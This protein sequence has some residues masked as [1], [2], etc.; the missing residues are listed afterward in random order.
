M[1][2][3]AND[4]KSF[5]KAGYPVLYLVSWEEERVENK[6]RVI[7]KE[8]YGDSFKFY[9]WSCTDGLVTYG[10]GGVE[11]TR[12]VYRA[13]DR[14]ISINEEAFF[15]F[16]DLSFFIKEPQTL[17]RL[18]DIQRTL[19]GGSKTL[20]VLSSSLNLPGELENLVPVVDIDLPDADEIGDVFDSVVNQCV[21]EGV[22][23]FITPEFRERCIRALLGLGTAEIELA[24]KRVLIGIEELDEDR[25][26]ELLLEEKA[27]F[28]RKSGTLEFVRGRISLD[29]IG[30]LDNLKEWL[31]IRSLAFSPD[32][33]NFGLDVPKGVLIMGISGCGKSLCAKAI[34]TVWGLPLLRLDLNQVY[35]GSFGTPEEAFR[36]AIKTVEAVAPCVLWI[37]EIEAGI[38]RSG[39]KTGDSPT[40]RIFGYFLTWMQEKEKMVFIAAT[41]NQ[42]DL[43]PPELLR[44]GRFDEIFFVSLP[45]REERKEIF[46][47]HL[48][49]RGKNPDLFDLDSLAKNTEGLSGAEIEQAVVSALFE[50]FSKQKELDDKD[51]IIAAS[52]IVPLST[53][54]REEISKIERWASNRAVRASK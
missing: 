28:I 54:M 19:R 31:K 30:G 40:S 39:E 34:A 7:G 18:K 42:I 4:I 17:R 12:D 51:L 9:T 53:T 8:L 26:V 2:F 41:A 47:I 5:V 35:S 24:L 38:T 6:L 49:K 25:V 16:K 37:D 10:E 29:S 20:F 52:S 22:F 21:K 27:Q 50:S 32:A 11:E 14:V 1:P 15:L 46:R 44:K 48:A 36:K 3:P 43:L 23:S 45:S 33:K 13:L